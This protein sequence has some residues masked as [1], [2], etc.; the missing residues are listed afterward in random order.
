MITMTLMKKMGGVAIACS[1]PKIVNAVEKLF[2]PDPEQR[3]SGFDT[4]E[5]ELIATKAKLDVANTTINNF[6]AALDQ[7]ENSVNI[8]LQKKID[9]ESTPEVLVADPDLPDF[10]N[11]PVNLLAEAMTPAKKEIG[12]APVNMDYDA[13]SSK[14]VIDPVVH[15]AKLQYR[16]PDKQPRDSTKMYLAHALLALRLRREFDDK[17]R[18]VPQPTRPKLTTLAVRLNEITG[19]HKSDTVWGKIWTGVKPLSDFE[20]SDY[21]FDW[22]KTS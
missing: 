2:T 13:Y 15:P 4:V 21:E 5:H 14:P 22:E 10:T 9:E 12:E 8:L 19:L 3:P 1:I 11:P 20:E 7:A 17:W 18:G 6:K 16:G